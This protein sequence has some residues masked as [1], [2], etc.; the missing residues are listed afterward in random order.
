MRTKKSLKHSVITFHKRYW[1]RKDQACLEDGRRRVV[2][3]KLYYYPASCEG[4]EVIINV[5]EEAGSRKRYLRL[6]PQKKEAAIEII[7]RYILKGFI[8][9]EMRSEELFIDFIKSGKGEICKL[10]EEVVRIYTEKAIEGIEKEARIYLRQEIHNY[11]HIHYILE[12]IKKELEKRPVSFVDNEKQISINLILSFLE[13]A[14]TQKYILTSVMKN[15]I[16]G[17][18]VKTSKK[19]CSAIKNA[20]KDRIIYYIDNVLVKSNYLE[21]M[22]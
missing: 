17:E 10:T 1:T 16:F 19:Y 9:E 12:V 2:A 20:I 14:K 3:D 5:M 21:Y 8:Q 18:D 22:Q 4:K 13:N 15:Y 11:I 6:T 7:R